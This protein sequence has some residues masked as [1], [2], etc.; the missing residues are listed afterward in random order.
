MGI[1]IA[2]RGSIAVKAIVTPPPETPEITL[3]TVEGNIV[4]HEFETVAN[5]TLYRIETEK[6]G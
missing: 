3:I 1:T 6:V 2:R 5:S 4:S